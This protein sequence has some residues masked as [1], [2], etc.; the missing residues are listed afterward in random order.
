[1]H[2]SEDL[3]SFAQ[4]ICPI[5]TMIGVILTL[6]VTIH[7]NRD[8]LMDSVYGGHPAGCGGHPA[9]YDPIGQ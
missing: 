8:I 9:H 2:V 3:K 7:I 1:M 4:Y 6:V 5:L